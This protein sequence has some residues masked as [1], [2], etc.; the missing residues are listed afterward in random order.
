MKYMNIV[1][2]KSQ[3]EFE[4]DGEEDLVKKLEDIYTLFGV[5]PTIQ[6]TGDVIHIN[7]NSNLFESIEK[8]FDK[9]SDLCNKSKFQEAQIILERV[10]SKC[11]LFVEAHRM[12]AQTYMMRG[13]YE[14]AMNANLETL[15]Y[16]PQNLWGLILMG[17]IFARMDDLDTADSYYNK[18]LVYHPNSPVALNN[19]AGMK[20]EREK[21]QE[22]IEL[23]DKVISLDKTY[24]NA[25]YGKALSYMHLYKYYDAFNVCIDA[26]VSSVERK[27]NPAVMSELKKLLITAARNIY[28][29]GNLEDIVEEVKCKLEQ[30]GG[31]KVIAESVENLDL[32][33]QL[34]YSKTHKRDYHKIIYNPTKK[35]YEHFMMHELM[36]LD[37][38]LAASNVSKN[39]ILYSDE[40]CTCAFLKKFNFG[41]LKKRFGND[42]VANFINKMQRGI[43]LQLLNC[44]L[45]L[46][47]EDK[48]YDNYP[49]FRPIQLLSLF[50]QEEENIKSIEQTSKMKEIPSKIVSINKVLNIVSSLHFKD[51]YG[52]DFIYRYKAT[53][54][55]L[56][57]AIDLYE[58]YKAYRGDYQPGEEYDL[59]TYFIESLDCEDIVKF[60]NEIHNADIMAEIPNEAP[61]SSPDVYEKNQEF[62]E[63]RKKADADGA[64][65]FMM[66]MY[67][68][69]AI[70]YLEKLSREDVK[71][72]ALE[73]A[74]VGIN[75]ISPNNDGYKINAIPN[76]EFKGYE[77]LAYYYVSWAIAIP[78]QV[79][80]LGLPFKAAYDSA[81]ALHKAKNNRQ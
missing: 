17:N 32:I 19:I 80:S 71:R 38:N 31:R 72:I 57:T 16:D 18:V 34:Q 50:A 60:M 20:V 23:F 49:D 1:L 7:I 6:I 73:I 40:G 65:T 51:L 70:E 53:K 46:L 9:A 62:A 63:N 78:E 27:E 21:F 30:K 81:V 43:S 15:R 3:V 36:H 61:M 24:A 14:S 29:P 79:D 67:M 42:V 69:G 37:M 33:A 44:P 41:A 76:K 4:F 55:E 10:I 8:D 45:D 28:K 26:L 39:K 74:I 25:Y 5:K 47:V 56:D 68:L 54:S 66:T 58:E 75:G 48:I 22:A 64:E 35:Y 77:F 13:D 2:F 12:L 59:V 11:P 52:Y